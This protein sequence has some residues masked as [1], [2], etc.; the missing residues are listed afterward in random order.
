VACYCIGL[1]LALAANL[2]PLSA[3]RVHRQLQHEH[4]G[5]ARQPVGAPQSLGGAASQ[6]SSGSPGGQSAAESSAQTGEHAPKGPH[7]TEATPQTPQASQAAEEEPAEARPPQVSEHLS[8]SYCLNGGTF[9]LTED[10]HI[11]CHCPPEFYGTRC[12]TRD[13]CKTS[14]VDNLT[15]EQICQKIGRS[16]MRN[17]KFFRCLCQADEYFVYRTP[18]QLFEQQQEQLQKQQ[19]SKS[20]TSSR[21]QPTPSTFV[22]D[23]PLAGLGESGREAE[24]KEFGGSVR[25][26]EAPQMA[27]PSY[28]AECRRVDRCVGV[29]CR[30]MSEVCVDGEC[31]CNRA[32]GYARDP[33]DSFCKLLDPCRTAGPLGPEGRPARACGDQ[34]KCVPT[35]D[36]D[37]YRCVCPVGYSAVRREASPNSTQCVLMNDLIC[38]VPLLNRCQHLCRVDHVANVALCSCL[39]GYR[40]G[41]RPGLDD[42]LCFFQAQ[43]ELGEQQESEESR[44]SGE[45]G[46]SGESGEPL[47]RELG[48]GGG[49]LK[50]GEKAG[51]Q[52]RPAVKYTFRPYRRVAASEQA[53]ER[54]EYDADLDVLLV[55]WLLSGNDS[56]LAARRGGPQLLVKREP[57]LRP[58]GHLGPLEEEARRKMGQGEAL[59]T[60]KGWKLGGRNSGRLSVEEQLAGMSEQQRCN[61]YCDTNEICVLE[62]DSADTYRCSC[63]RQGY[64]RMEHKCVDWCTALS[65]ELADGVRAVHR[66]GLSAAC[67]S[68][69][70]RT[71]Q[72][73]AR[74][75]Q[76]LNR[77]R[78]QPV[79][80]LWPPDDEDEEERDEQHTESTRRR[81]EELLEEDGGQSSGESSKDEKADD[82]G[83]WA[84]LEGSSWRPEF[85]C[86]CDSSPLLTTDPESRLCQLN[87]TQILRPCLPGNE[88]H[89]ECVVNKHS[90]CA[91]LHQN[92]NA[93]RAEL[94]AP[95]LRPSKQSEAKRKQH[96]QSEAGQW[97]G[98]RLARGASERQGSTTKGRL[99]QAE[100]E[101]KAYTCVCAPEK[102]LLV[103]KPRNKARCIDECDLL[104]VECGRFNRMCRLATIMADDFGSQPLVQEERDGTIRMSQ[105]KRTGC[106]C[107]PGFNVGPSESVDFT[108]D[109]NYGSEEEA[110]AGGAGGGQQQQGVFGGGASGNPFDPLPSLDGLSGSGEAGQTELERARYMNINSRCLLDYDVVQFHA[111][112]KAPADFEPSWVHV[113]NCEGCRWNAR[114][115]RQGGAAAG[116]KQSHTSASG[117]S[118]GARSAGAWRGSESARDQWASWT[119]T[120]QPPEGAGS[121]GSTG[122]GSGGADGKS[123]GRRGVSSGCRNSQECL[124]RMPKFML[125]DI[126]E[127]N[128]HM[129]L[130]AHCHPSLA[131][132]SL[133][134]YDQCTRYR[135]WIVQKL[136]HHYADWRKVVTER[137][138]GT[139][140]L[141]E[142]NIRLRVNKCH[143]VIRRIETVAEARAWSLA[144]E[145]QLPATDEEQPRDWAGPAGAQ[146]HASSPELLLLELANTM[147][148]S[149]A[150]DAPEGAPQPDGS[151]S[152]GAGGELPRRR[153]VQP[154]DF[155]PYDQFALVD[156]DINCELTLHSARN[157]TLHKH[158]RKV[159]LEKQLPKFIFDRPSGEPEPTMDNGQPMPAAAGDQPSTS[160][161]NEAS[162]GPQTGSGSGGGGSYYLMAPDSLISKHSVDQLAS[163]RKPFNPCASDY[164]Y[165]DGQTRCKMVDTVNFT[166]TCDYGYTPI[167]SRD[168]YLGDSRKDVCEDIDECLF[169]VCKENGLEN[170][171]TCVNQIG[172]YRC[173]CKPHYV[174]DNR[175]KCDHI[176][177]VVSCKYG[178]CRIPEDYHIYC[179]CYEGYIEADCSV[180]DPSIALRKANMIICGSIFTSVLLLLTTLATN[181]NSQL[182]KT[183]KKLKRLEAT[184]ETSNLFELPPKQT[185]FR[186]RVS[187]V[188]SGS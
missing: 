79:G 22:Y 73:D 91:V 177:D 133:D 35:F 10:G 120:Q 111:T 163:H 107:L 18:E 67:L 182:K 117:P 141:M 136:R 97:L 124:L 44:E 27:R 88:G 179:D 28:L 38:R 59:G 116:K 98:G 36:R 57:V 176:C 109:D 61:M 16:C 6:D 23:G 127:L 64:V 31:V 149:A 105:F 21:Q 146:R 47:E 45:S 34:A 144:D 40:A 56:L 125:A 129:V 118:E 50:G 123:A 188:S 137:L 102:K 101:R 63:K 166:C 76:L 168:I 82:L 2:R 77:Y 14:I 66:L 48:G 15:G 170:V 37:S 58:G 178:D 12:Q 52:Q 5:D 135:Y 74:L 49:S 81:R 122:G 167:G 32:L 131:A 80:S 130:V 112:F 187:K 68:G 89:Q 11:M 152:L 113:A 19:L 62:W 183:K 55:E 94:L 110:A 151:S 150:H 162:E 161:R 1:L 115:N 41:E 106:E 172:D 78:S 92:I 165:C 20:G 51:R 95:H 171:S 90:Y 169:D 70:C 100:T 173:Q 93:F 17:D 175:Y 181:L 185:P 7:D 154:R 145:Q 119:G 159:L 99:G 54:H 26:E 186:T 60:V 86:N 160:K 3:A 69:A 157:G 13:I 155:N 128:R 138:K 87:F 142:G 30:Q 25:G 143:S 65:M 126:E 9:V 39:P 84:V 184:Y 4:G 114:P 71:S 53:P 132:L 43:G 153:I 174:G 72:R 156:A 180:Q 108:L 83:D 46:G 104:N 121:S 33:H 164:P 42:H 147:G 8:D 134:M 103:D 29:R 85:E 75:H 140:D 148:A 24:V 139:F 158:S 96:G